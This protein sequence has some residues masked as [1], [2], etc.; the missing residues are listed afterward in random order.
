MDTNVYHPDYYRVIERVVGGWHF[1]KG[2][3]F[4]K[5]LPISINF[6][7]FELLY[8]ITKQQVAIELFRLESVKAGYYLADLRH[9]QFY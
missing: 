6:D 8:G 2:K 7:D 1:K 9:K 4:Y 5:H 3:L